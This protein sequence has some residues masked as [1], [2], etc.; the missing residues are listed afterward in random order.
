MTWD[1][2]IIPANEIK[3]RAHDAEK[4]GKTSISRAQKGPTV[5]QPNQSQTICIIGIARDI[6]T[7][8]Y[9]VDFEFTTVD[10]HVKNISLRR[11]LSERDMA[12]ELLQ[13]GAQLPHGYP[14]ATKIVQGLLQGTAPPTYD[15]SALTGWVDGSFR[16]VDKNYRA[17]CGFPADAPAERPFKGPANSG[18]VGRVEERV[19]F[20]L[21]QVFLPHDFHRLWLRGPTAKT[22]RNTRERLNLLPGA[23]LHGQDDCAQGGKVRCRQS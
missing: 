15:I 9:C 1:E 20:A 13:R 6:D 11:D 7:D 4:P 17:S 14:Q 23:E 22:G 5:N 2:L 19:G 16:M 12:K 21:R 8:R 10:G 18:Y 3:A